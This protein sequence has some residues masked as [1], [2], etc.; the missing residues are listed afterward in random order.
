M[1]STKR[2]SGLAPSEFSAA[3]SEADKKV[4]AGAH[5]EVTES[6]SQKA[7]RLFEQM[8]KEIREKR[9][10]AKL[11]GK[12]ESEVKAIKFDKESS[13][14]KEWMEACSDNFYNG[15]VQ[16]EEEAAQAMEKSER[17]GEDVDANGLRD[18]WIAA[19][20]KM[21]DVKLA[22]Q[23][24]KELLDQKNDT[25][26][27]RDDLEEKSDQ[28][29][30][31]NPAIEK[32][33]IVLDAQDDLTEV[34]LSAVDAL[35]VGEEDEVLVLPP[36]IPADY[37]EII[38]LNELEEITDE[39]AGDQWSEPDYE[40]R[41]FAQPESVES[42]SKTAGADT[43]RSHF[44]DLLSRDQKSGIGFRE[45]IFNAKLN[46]LVGE[47]VVFAGLLLKDQNFIKSVNNFF[48]AKIGLF[49][50]KVLEKAAQFA[51]II[52]E[53]RVTYDNLRTA[54]E[55]KPN[56]LEIEAEN[57]DEE[58]DEAD[59]SLEEPVVQAEEGSHQVQSREDVKS[60]LKAL[61]PEG[62]EHPE[63]TSQQVS[64]LQADMDVLRKNWQ[65]QQDAYNQTKFYQVFKRSALKSE[66]DKTQDQIKDLAQ[67]LIDLGDQLTAQD[68]ASK[69]LPDSEMARLNK[70]VGEHLKQ[71]KQELSKNDTRSIIDKHGDLAA[72][73][74]AFLGMATVYFNVSEAK[75]EDIDFSKSAIVTTYDQ[76][77]VDKQSSVFVPKLDV[78]QPKQVITEV[79]FTPSSSSAVREDK[80][81]TSA[82]PEV[83][84]AETQPEASV[85][86][87]PVVKVARKESRSK[88]HKIERN[89]TTVPKAEVKKTPSLNELDQRIASLETEI[90]TL[91]DR[92]AELPPVLDIGSLSP[93]EI[94]KLKTD[95]NGENQLSKAM[96]EKQAQLK[97]LENQRATLLAEQKAKN[98]EPVAQ[99]TDEY[100]DFSKIT[101]DFTVNNLD[102]DKDITFFV[103]GPYANDLSNAHDIVR[104]I[105]NFA[106][107]TNDETQ[108][109][110]YLE[111]AKKAE[112]L[113]KLILG[114]K[115]TDNAP[116]DH[117]LKQ[118]DG[119]LDLVRKQI[120]AIEKSLPTR[121]ASSVKADA[122]VSLNKIVEDNKNRVYV[123][124]GARGLDERALHGVGGA[125]ELL[126]E[127]LELNLGKGVQLKKLEQAITKIGIVL[128]DS[129]SESTL[130]A[131]AK[132]LSK[133]ARDLR[134]S[135]SLPK[136]PDIAPPVVPVDSDDALRRKVDK[137]AQEI[138]DARDA[139]QNN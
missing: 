92:I 112:I 86:N 29:G 82:L 127:V 115:G 13:V 128:N 38:T 37:V 119:G 97:G 121:D 79:P 7:A 70:L 56:L 108:L 57:T 98:A 59:V 134:Q 47:D 44:G 41:F 126:Q 12:S 99:Y 91:R 68:I 42:T 14:Y 106:G 80:K 122:L 30:G 118:A 71:L 16:A 138:M 117:T 69:L 78:R 8:N 4:E 34:Q 28:L 132:V 52:K 18:K 107:R 76:P 11:E 51:F 85:T 48:N 1:P 114:A 139:A 53:A 39:V 113:Y 90:T 103:S 125:V 25:Q 64:K 110:K 72:I 83:Q 24:K 133:V 3:D 26:D 5:L 95:P 9:K 73:V 19:F 137:E 60:Y 89:R 23:I 129:S 62:F 49:S 67:V 77:K 40:R 22:R 120:A 50:N 116:N 10:Q 43:I 20:R 17:D 84:S 135:L 81:E 6:S 102:S 100:I 74:F 66:V 55:E 96:A 36:P 31:E 94:D 104:S 2:E 46:D 136:A 123:R 130:R 105:Q 75:R 87:K 32:E 15:L 35:S 131:E 54:L 58:V 27:R 111:E 33:Q 21:H 63:Q 88:K 109:R 45:S 65:I 124:K 61:I 93:E 101:P